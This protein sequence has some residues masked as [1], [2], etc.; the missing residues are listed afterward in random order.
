MN[1]ENNEFIPSDYKIPTTSNYMK[2]T[3]GEHTFRVLSSAIVGYEYFNSDNKPVRSKEPFEEAPSDMKSG[4]RINPFW[5][6]LIWNYDAK[7]IQI[8]EITQKTIM[9]PL[10][11]L[12]KNPKW[13]NPRGYDITITRK[14]SGMQDTEYA[15]VPNPHTALDASIAEQFKKSTID[16]E[17]L[18]VGGDPFNPNK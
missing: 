14:G 18:C 5:A 16:L 17:L 4:G 6:F 11:A 3:E 10:Q 15:V 7:R 1:K 12:I 8:M 9:M 13:G 2:L